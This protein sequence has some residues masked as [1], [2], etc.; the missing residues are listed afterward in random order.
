MQRGNSIRFK[1]RRDWHMD[2]EFSRP[3]P[4][5]PAH[6]AEMI[7]MNVRQNNMQR[8]KFVKFFPH[9]LTCQSFDASSGIKQDSDLVRRD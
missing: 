1:I 4:Q 6:P 8:S 2:N 7:A 5:Q 9:S 3:K